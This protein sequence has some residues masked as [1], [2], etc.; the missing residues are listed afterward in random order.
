[1][2]I[3]T[4]AKLGMSKK[5]VLCFSGGID[6]SVL[7]HLAAANGYK[8]IFTLSFDYGQRHKRELKCCQAQLTD[9]LNK[10][11]KSITASKKIVDV[12]Y[13]R[14]IAP[15][16]SL[17][18]DSIVTPNIKEIAGEA[19]PLHYVPYRNTQFL[20]IACAYAEANKVETIWYG[21]ALADSLGGVWDADQYYID[22]LNR[23]IGLNRQHKISIEA[24]LLNKSKTEII[25]IGVE[26]GVNF[27][28]TWTCYAG[29]DL[30]D[31]DSSSSA[32]RLRGFIDA[33]YKDPLQYKQQAELN[34]VYKKNKCKAIKF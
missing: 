4:I 21:A 9:I 16:S 3:G 23:V 27:A 22:A 17:T 7:L 29:K 34:K 8:E 14:D 19:Q 10:Y 32:L 25:K 6:S 26:L 18:N 20:S 30:A 33:G 5:L 24:P 11:G 2:S 1:M 15:T 28:N 12:R 31:A 13:I